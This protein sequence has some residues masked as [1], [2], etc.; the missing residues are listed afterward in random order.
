M[1]HDNSYKNLDVYVVSWGGVGTT[2]IMDFLLDYNIK[3]NCLHDFDKIKHINSPNHEKL[4]NIKIKKT[5]FI[6]DDV[7]NSILSL[8]RRKFQHK[9][10][11]KITDGKETLGKDG[12]LTKYCDNNRDLFKFQTF[13]NNWIKNEKEYPCIF[14]KGQQLYKYKYHILKFLDLPMNIEFNIF[15]HKRSVNWRNKKEDK[16]IKR[17]YSIYGEFNDY[18]DSLP[19]IMLQKENSTEIIDLFSL[20]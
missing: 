8:W 18:I 4:K 15:H 13:F 1:S 5:I 17:L 2:A 9:Q 20:H 11:R 19:D 14:I 12:S 16:N 3:I 6:Y 7:I 10:L